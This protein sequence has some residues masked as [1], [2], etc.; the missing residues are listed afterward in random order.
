VLSQQL[1]L[2]SK[3]T[4]TKTRLS[5]PYLAFSRLF[6]PRHKPIL[7]LKLKKQPKMGF[8]KT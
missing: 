5:A 1:L 7:K 4:N 3:A 8:P 6:T 2:P